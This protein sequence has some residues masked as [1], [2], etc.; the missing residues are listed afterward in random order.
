MAGQERALEIS[1]AGIETTRGTAVAATRKVY[2]GWQPLGL[3]RELQWATT[4]TGTFENRREGSYDRQALT[5]PGTEGLTFEDAP[6]WFQFILKG[7]VTATTDGGSPPAYPYT[8]TPTLAADDLK[9]MTLELGTPTLPYEID[10]GMVNSATIRFSP[11]DAPYWEMD[12][13]L[14][15]RTL[16]QTAMTGSIA[17]RTRELIKA[18]GTKIYIDSAT[19]GTTQVTGR[20]I[21]GSVTI[22]NNL[23]FKSFAEDETAPA[24]N[25]VGRGDR[26]VDAQFAFEFDSD[27]EFLNFR[28]ATPVE[29]FIRIER[30]GATIHTTVKKRIRLDL[31]GY[32]TSVEPGYRN[33]NKI[34]TFSLGARYNTTSAY[35][36]SASVVNALSTLP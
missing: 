29:R 16:T 35:A 31:N 5:L 24:A 15:G 26:T 12:V 23:D 11:D 21:G 1:Q 10:Q 17:E 32:W 18:P 9:S 8:F 36:L 25:K 28:S 27:A 6:W 7:G 34:L 33:N 3:E 14:M 22:N 13:E 19:I 2:M 20:F 4:Q 30:E